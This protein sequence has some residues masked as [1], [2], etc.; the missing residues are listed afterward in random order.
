MRFGGHETFT[1]RE[2][3]L[4]KGINLLLENPKAYFDKVDLANALGVGVNMGKS[5]EH[6]LLATKLVKKIPLQEAREKGLK[7]EITE[8]ARTIHNKDPFMTQEETWWILHINMI[9]N[10]DYAATWDWF[11]NEFG[12]LKFDKIRLVKKL[13]EREK[14]LYKKTPSRST[15]ERDVSCFLNTYAQSIPREVKDPE[16]DYGSPFQELRLMNHQK[17]SGTYELLRRPRRLLPELFLYALNTIHG[18]EEG[19][20]DITLS[21]LTKQRSGP[22]QAFCLSSE[23]LFELAIGI[24]HA[25]QKY[26]YSVRSL[27]GDR[28]IVYSNP[29]NKTL[30]NNMYE[31][32]K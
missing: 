3:W 16:E 23:G 30:L 27:A 26:E 10:P 1:L 24:E 29:G 21:W 17:N 20:R 14:T 12:E 5:I 6:W 22:L 19:S 8:L 25:A 32:L 13:M 15:I 11:F 2:G 18:D 4:V 31:A 9:Q 7:Y 28:Q